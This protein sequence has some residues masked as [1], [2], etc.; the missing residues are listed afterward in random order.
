MHKH[1]ARGRR[2]ANVSP[3]PGPSPPRPP[4]SESP[5]LLVHGGKTSSA[6]WQPLPYLTIQCEVLA[7]DRRG[8]GGRG[9]QSP[10]SLDWEFQDVAA[11]AGLGHEGVDTAPRPGGSPVGDGTQGVRRPHGAKV[12][13]RS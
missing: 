1:A 8:R 13:G 10:C 3:G 11:L 9:D 12:G 7:R 5:L 6:R 4:G 2:T